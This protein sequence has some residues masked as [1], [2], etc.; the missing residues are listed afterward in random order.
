[1]SVVSTG[2]QSLEARTMR[3]VAVRALPFLM[4]LYFVNYLDRTNLGIAK[5]DIS[6]H[7][8]LTASMFGLAS[9]IFFIGYVLV[10]VPSNLALERFGARRWLARIAVSWGIV[11]VAIGFAPNAPTLLAL[12][13]LLGV[14]EAGLFPG[15]IFY[16]T[17]WFPAAYRARIVALFMMA[18][19][20]AAAVGTPLAAWM[21]QAGEGTFGLAGWQF[22]MIGVGL[23]AIILGVICW[24]YLTD[25]PA[26]AHWLQPDERQW[27]TDVLAEEER[28]VAASFDFPLRRALTSPR[29]WLLALV[30]FG[31]A[32]GLYALA[33]FLP[34]IISDFKK[35]FDVHLSIVQVG[36]ITAVPYTLAAIAMYLWSRHADRQNEHVWHVAIP[37][38]L[39]GLAIPI[40]LYLDSPLL[41]MI[42]VCIT[43]MGVFSAIPSFWAL[44][45]QFLT[46]AAAAGGIGLINSI[47]NLGGFAAP[48]ATGALNQFTGSDKAG[49]WAVGIVMLISAVVVVVL[50]ATPDRDTQQ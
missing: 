42:P 50:R 9:G 15:V 6:E 2:E 4:A 17:R 18:S 36:L 31:V 21:I 24:F 3:K 23:P 5:A 44:P 46:G 26:E 48:Y 37:M 30:Y 34:S 45:A 43:A 35:T 38:G 40:A 10:E 13:F 7:L 29:I 1:M 28:D 20:I 41:V 8:Q 25:R 49:M 12:R 11:A 14:A 16:L 47:G 33:F 27:L 22:M 19:P 39:G 32:Y